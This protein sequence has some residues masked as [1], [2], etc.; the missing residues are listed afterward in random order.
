MKRDNGASA[1]CLK[2]E[3]RLQGPIEWG[4]RPLCPASKLDWDEIKRLAKENKLDDIDS[5]VYVR[6]YNTLLR[7]AKDH[8]EIPDR[9]FEKELLWIYG[10]PRTGK[11]RVARQ[12]KHYLKLA[13]KW[14]DGYKP[15][16]HTAVVIDDLGKDKAKALTDH[17]KLWAD[18]W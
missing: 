7:I 15:E 8:M 1:Y 12:D 16:K 3:T 14:W 4:K 9:T 6:Y 2:E 18:P 10:P 13:N 17:I 5:G 11:S